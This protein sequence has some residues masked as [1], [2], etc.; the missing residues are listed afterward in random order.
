MSQQKKIPIM[1]FQAPYAS[2]IERG[3]YLPMHDLDHP[4]CGVVPAEYY[5]TAFNGEIECSQQLPEDCEQRTHTILE[6]VYTIF[7]TAHPVGYCGRSISVGD[8]VKL[9]GNYYLCAAIGFKQVEFQSSPDHP[10]ANPTVCPM[11]LPD[12]TALRVAI[13]K[14]TLY[15]GI[16]IDMVAADGTETQVCFVEHN[17]E[18]APGHE[19][20]IGV[21]CD[22]EEDTVYYDSY[23]RERKNDIN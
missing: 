14:E 22:T 18:M 5:L 11:V 8:V 2:L 10:T 20:C 19:L 4:F 9:E 12:G 3:L 6:W 13:C 21:Y 1:I 23:Y 15:P 17:P 16:N 7:N